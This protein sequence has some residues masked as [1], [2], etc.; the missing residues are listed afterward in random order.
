VLVQ[1]K[2]V[3]AECSQLVK[4]PDQSLSY[5]EAFLDPA[6]LVNSLSEKGITQEWLLEQLIDVAG[7]T[8]KDSVRLAAIRE[9]R[10]IIS[11]VA[12]HA[13]L[14]AKVTQTRIMEDGSTLSAERVANVLGPNP[15]PR[16]EILNDETDEPEDTIETIETIETEEEEEEGDEAQEES[17]G[18]QTEGPTDGQDNQP[19]TARR[20]PVGERNDSDSGSTGS[21]DKGDEDLDGATTDEDERRGDL[22][23]HKPPPAG[24]EKLFPGAARQKYRPPAG[25]GF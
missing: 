3:G 15:S 11:E 17:E 7:N 19:R 25:S 6:A 10:R 4:Q 5:L 21:S 9:I 13:G 8:E 16:K 18:A 2:N 24:N 22:D 23:D 12:E 14:I 1:L 20:E